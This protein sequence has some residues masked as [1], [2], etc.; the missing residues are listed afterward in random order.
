MIYKHNQC[1]T[2]SKFVDIIEQ[3]EK[4]LPKQYKYYCYRCQAYYTKHNLLDYDE[5]IQLK[6]F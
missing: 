1:K 6:L 5:P 4:K 3:R 2:I